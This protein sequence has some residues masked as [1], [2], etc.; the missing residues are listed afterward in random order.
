MI[1]RRRPAGRGRALPAVAAAAALAAACGA[2]VERE[3]SWT[4]L[5]APA[6]ARVVAVTDAAADELLAA[7]QDAGERA[8][9]IVGPGSDTAL[10]RL[11]QAA[12]LGFHRVEPREL[13]RTLLRALDYARASDGTYDS[14]GQTLFFARPDFHRNNT[15]RYQ[16]GTARNIWKEYWSA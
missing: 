15:K 6:D 16:G 8:A 13:W 11:Q 3:A 4:T 5:G 14:S 2:P 1:R 12:P 10:G 7:L 9:T